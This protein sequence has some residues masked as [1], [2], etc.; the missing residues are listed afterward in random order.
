MPVSS[1]KRF[2]KRGIKIAAGA[3]ESKKIVSVIDFDLW[4]ENAAGGPRRF[5]ARP[6]AFNQH[7]VADAALPERARN[8]QSD[9][10]AA[11]DDDIRRFVW[12][13][14]FAKGHNEE[15]SVV[16]CQLSVEVLC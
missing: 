10:A 7:H 2:G 3:G 11:D 12:S 5:R 9:H 8:R 13:K 14:G 6:P 4:R 15:W 1:L 16:S